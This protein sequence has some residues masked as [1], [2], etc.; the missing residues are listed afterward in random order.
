MNE[1]LEFIIFVRRILTKKNFAIAQFIIDGAKNGDFV[2]L[3]VFLS[4]SAQYI[5][6]S[7]S[8]RKQLFLKGFLKRLNIP[9]RYGEFYY[10]KL[11]I[12]FSNK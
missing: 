9:N 8:F 6:N 1:L 12:R 4:F 2:I 3:H 5:G 7:N 10:I 11:V